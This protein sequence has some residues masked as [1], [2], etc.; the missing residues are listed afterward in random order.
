MR[1][2][3]CKFR[4]DFYSA[5]SYIVCAAMKVAISFG[6]TADA[7]AKPQGR[8]RFLFGS[9]VMQKSNA[10]RRCEAAIN[11][12]YNDTAF[13]SALYRLKAFGVLKMA[14]ESERSR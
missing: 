11:A 6:D 7:T 9:A 4:R 2:A 5:I 3:T 10:A 1:S 13:C 8:P 14:C 12:M